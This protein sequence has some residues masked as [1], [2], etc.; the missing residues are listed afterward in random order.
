ME[1]DSVP[2]TLPRLSAGKIL[3]ALARF[4]VLALLLA[5]GLGIGVLWSFF[6]GG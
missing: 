6:Q 1:P 2:A 3:H 4:L 5:V